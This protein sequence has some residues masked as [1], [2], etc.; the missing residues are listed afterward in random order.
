MATLTS[1]GVNCSD[2]TLDG[3]YTGTSTSNTSF[4]IGSY[5]FCGTNVGTAP[6]NVFVNNNVPYVK[7]STIANF[8]RVYFFISANAS[9]SGFANLSGTW[10]SRGAYG[11]DGCNFNVYNG[12]FQR[13]A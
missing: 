10:R 2:G 12:M 3:Q 8:N 6:Q 13:V 1:S 4:P 7:T 5:L 11:S 9:N